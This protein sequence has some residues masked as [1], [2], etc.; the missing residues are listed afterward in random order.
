MY[1]WLRFITNLKETLVLSEFLSSVAQQEQEET[2]KA[3]VNLE[4]DF[5]PDRWQ[6]L[7]TMN[8]TVKLMMMNQR[9]HQPVGNLVAERDEWYK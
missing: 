2:E 3:E 9:C 6:N 7:T 4:A 5:D 1:L 8:I